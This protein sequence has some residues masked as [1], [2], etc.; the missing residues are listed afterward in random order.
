MKKRWYA[1]LLIGAVFLAG[2]V[3]G[4]V[5]L[6]NWWNDGRLIQQEAEEIANDF[7]LPESTQP[8]VPPSSDI[9]DE[10]DGQEASEMPQQQESNTKPLS[11]LDYEKLIAANSEA[12]GW[13]RIEGTSVNHPLMQTSN[14]TK[15]MSQ[16]IYGE[17]SSAGTPF[18]DCT[19]A[20][21]PMDSNLVVYGHNMG[22]GRT[23]AFSTLTKYKRQSQWGNYPLIE[24]N[25]KG[26]T[27]MWRIFAV[28]EF[29]IDNLSDYNYTTHNFLTGENKLAFAN[30]AKARSVYDTGVEVN[31]EDHILTLSTCDHSV[32]GTKGRIVIMAVQE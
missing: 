15:Y 23:S 30:E 14:N 8:T 9:S 13:I 4:G 28:L 17:K 10:T 22:I 27:S 2:L 3:Y 6:Y 25:L 16:N 18:L 5:E 12:I 19:N 11:S 1:W 7:L 26:E 31:A 32:Y 21:E 24:L 29:N 20:L